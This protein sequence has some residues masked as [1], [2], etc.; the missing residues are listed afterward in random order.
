M[1]VTFNLAVVAAPY[2]Q[3]EATSH[4][5]PARISIDMRSRWK[6]AIPRRTIVIMKLHLVMELKKKG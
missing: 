6:M 4:A 2:S 5:L 1:E 3:P